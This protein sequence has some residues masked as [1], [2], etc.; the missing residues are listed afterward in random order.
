M[1]HR[2]GESKYPSTNTTNEQL[3][4]HLSY[5]TENNFDF[6]FARDLL[7]PEALFKKTISITVDD[8]YLSFY[9]VGLP[10]F[11][12]FD[13]PVTLFLNTEN[14]GGNN[15]MSWQQLKD[16]LTRGIDIQNHTHSHSSLSVLSDEE[17]INEIEKSQELI[18]N[19]L[20][21]TP[22]LFAYPFGENS[23]KAQG[24]VSN[25]FDAAFGQHSGAFSI[26]QKYYIPRFPLNENYGS[27][28]RIRDAA[29]SLPFSKALLQPADPFLNPASTR[30][31][32]SVEGGVQNVNCFISD[33]EG[34]IGKTTTSLEDKLL[35][36]LDRMPVKGRLR[37]NCTKVDNGV[38]WYGYQ[39]LIN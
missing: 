6:I 21:I 3:E 34:S 31:V 35:I 27:L 12:K 25:Y 16:T 32:L 14:V 10:I 7:K 30:F 24:I 20:G 15:Y 36:E 22:N 11:E 1:Y 13:I 37:F 38:Y 39:Y 28:D 18:F 33:F 5:L 29:N 19:N 2:F 4:E 17:I 8:A 23:L 9:E 26:D